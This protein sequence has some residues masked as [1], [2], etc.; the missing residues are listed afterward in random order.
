MGLQDI[1]DAAGMSVFHFAR[2][3]KYATGEPP[4]RY[5]TELR[6]AEARTLLHTRGSRSARWRG[7]GE[8]SEGKERGAATSGQEPLCPRAGGHHGLV[9]ATPVCADPR[10]AH[11]SGCEDAGLLCL[12][13]HIG[14][15][16]TIGLACNERRKD[17]DEVAVAARQWPE[18]ETIQC[19]SLSAS[20]TRSPDPASLHRCARS[21]PVKKRMPEICTSGT[22]RGGWQHPHLLGGYT[23]NRTGLVAPGPAAIPGLGTERRRHQPQYAV[24][25]P[26]GVGS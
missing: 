14:Q 17:W 21:S 6:L 9:P 12:I 24:F 8:V 13:R 1:A 7:L 3:F 18:L 11:S 10:A 26:E 22:A 5:L 2:G 4:H 23:S 20:A 19:A 16:S 25:P 15:L